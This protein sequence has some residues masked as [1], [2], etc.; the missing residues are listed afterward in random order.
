MTSGSVTLN[1]ISDHD[2][3]IVLEV[4]QKHEGKLSFNPQQM[5]ATTQGAPPASSYNNVILGWNGHPGLHA[6][7][8]ILER[9]NSETKHQ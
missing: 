8:E 5:Q 3:V 4:K 1:G 9:L 7:R 6:V 2:L